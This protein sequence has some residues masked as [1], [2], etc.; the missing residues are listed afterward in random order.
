M[1]YVDKELLSNI[2]SNLH[3]LDFNIAVDKQF[4]LKF[5]DSLDN[6]NEIIHFKS[7][8][9]FIVYWFFKGLKNI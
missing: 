9:Y 7:Q 8:R 5:R 6:A 1:L 4:K 3:Q 2:T